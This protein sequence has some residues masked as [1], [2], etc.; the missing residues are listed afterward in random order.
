MRVKLFWQYMN[1]VTIRRF[2]AYLQH[3]NEME[4]YLAGREQQAAK[5]QQR[6]EKDQNKRAL[7]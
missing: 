1:G 6:I 7:S 5:V 4:R 2:S 3:R